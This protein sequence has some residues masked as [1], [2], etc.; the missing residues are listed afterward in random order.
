MSRDYFDMYYPFFPPIDLKCK[1]RHKG[2]MINISDDK[3]NK[4]RDVFIKAY[5]YPRIYLEK[6]GDKWVNHEL[7]EV[8]DPNLT[9]IL[10][11]EIKEKLNF[12]FFVNIN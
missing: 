7:K 12:K 4:I 10:D 8:V 1:T 9:K 2:E 11:D 3:C 5:R 6:Y